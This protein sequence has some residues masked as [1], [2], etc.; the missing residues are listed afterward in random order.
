DDRLHH[1]HQRCWPIR[2][3]TS[4]ECPI[5]FEGVARHAGPLLPPRRKKAAGG[6]VPLSTMA[7]SPQLHLRATDADRERVAAMLRA[8]GG[9]GALTVEE[10]EER[11]SAAYAAV[12]RAD[13]VGLVADLPPAGTA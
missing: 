8:A 4:D 13:L 2:C 12:T 11:L 10:L 7:E 1:R 9:D 3:L 5:R 6:F